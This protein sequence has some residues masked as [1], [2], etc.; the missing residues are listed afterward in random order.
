MFWFHLPPPCIELP[1]NFQAGAPGTYR[2]GWMQHSKVQNLVFR[3]NWPKRQAG[4]ADNKVKGV[5]DSSVAL[6]E[7][8]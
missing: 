2:F 1:H 6:Q 4:Q 5:F 7:K 3:D 8:S